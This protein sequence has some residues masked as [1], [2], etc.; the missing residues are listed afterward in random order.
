MPQRPQPHNRTHNRVDASGDEKWSQLC[1]EY[2][3]AEQAAMLAFEQLQ[4]HTPA[5]D[6]FEE[7][8]AAHR[9]LD[10]VVERMRK[11]LDRRAGIS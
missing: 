3:T 1:A 4:K 7:L 9:R 8:E 11:H 5:V 6:T 2:D 10:G